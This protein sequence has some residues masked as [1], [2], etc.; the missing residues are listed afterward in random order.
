MKTNN[1]FTLF[2]FILTSL[3]AN[4]K[5]IK[6]EPIEKTQTPKKKSIDINLSQIQPINKMMKNVTLIKQVL[7]LTNKKEKP[8]PTQNDKNWFVLNNE[9]TK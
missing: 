6:I 8:K 9:D 7:E 5:W 1:I 4:E 2:I 3:N